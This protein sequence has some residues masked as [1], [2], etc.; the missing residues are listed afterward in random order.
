[1]PCE[2]GLAGSPAQGEGRNMT[3]PSLS[4]IS[5]PP[6]DVPKS[7]LNPHLNQYKTEIDD[8]LRQDLALL[9]TLKN[10]FEA[11]N[12]IMYTLFPA[13]LG[14]SEINMATLANHL[15]VLSQDSQMI[16]YIQSVFN[17]SAADISG[18]KL[19]AG[20]YQKALD[21]G[22]ALLERGQDQVTDGVISE[23]TV[24]QFKTFLDELG[25]TS[26]SASD[27]EKQ[28]TSVWV[29]YDNPGVGKGIWGKQHGGGTQPGT[30]GEIKN[31][32][33]QFDQMSTTLNGTSQIVQSNDKFE[34]SQYN[35][36]VGVLKQVFASVAKEEKN[37]IDGS[38]QTS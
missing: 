13:F 16:A 34:T 27:L 1:M 3:D 18:S 17:G 29:T 24:E 15:K 11:I 20:S 25:M 5:K 7:V 8:Q 6:G 19:P 14:Q 36:E 4:V 37:A 31:Y 26:G 35:Q 2:V 38:K 32:E 28:W 22:K 10:A 23:S 9:K 33:D 30:F 12:Y 21:Y